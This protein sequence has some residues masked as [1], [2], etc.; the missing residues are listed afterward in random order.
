VI[1]PA[2][3]LEAFPDA[4]PVLDLPL[5]SP[6]VAG[7]PSSMAGPAIIQWIETA[8][9]LALSGAVS[10]VVTALLVPVA[11]RWLGTAMRPTPAATCPGAA[12]R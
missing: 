2:D 5:R 10:A 6:V 3:A 9:G 4:L 12:S 7:Q 11:A 8:V 1:A